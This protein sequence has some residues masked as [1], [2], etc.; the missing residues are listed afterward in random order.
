MGNGPG[1][2]NQETKSHPTLY[3]KRLI[4]QAVVGGH[5]QFLTKAQ[6]MPTHIEDALTKIIRNYIWDNNIHPRISLE[7]LYKPLNEGGLNLLDIKPQ[8]KVIEIIW[9]K[10]YLNLTPS[11]QMWA[12]ATDILIKASA[13]PECLQ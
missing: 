6:G 4:I 10:D 3:E 1:Q 9:L 11:R 13:P 2:N 7:H 5:T 12:R 8:N